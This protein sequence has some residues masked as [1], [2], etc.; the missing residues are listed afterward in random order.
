MFVGCGP[1]IR[2]AQQMQ[3]LAQSHLR[4]YP[5]RVWV[6]KETREIS[7][8]GTWSQPGPGSNRSSTTRRDTREVLEKLPTPN[9]RG[10]EGRSEGL[11]AHRSNMHLMHIHTGLF[12]E[13]RVQQRIPCPR[14]HGG[15]FG[16]RV[17]WHLADKRPWFPG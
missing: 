2:G 15:R 7:S 14:W 12:Q 13:T 3:V 1:S 8:R 5:G 10:T 17:A 9:R 11:F 4:D 16:D 6:I